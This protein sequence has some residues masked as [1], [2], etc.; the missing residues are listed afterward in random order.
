MS[1]TLIAQQLVVSLGLGMLIGFQRERSDRS[2][3][4]IRTFPLVTL[5]GTIS[6]QLA[7][8]YGGLIVAAG[9]LAL[10]ALTFLPNLPRFRTQEGTGVTSEIALL[11]LYLL[12]AF[13]VIEPLY[14]V[15]VT[16]GA[17]ALLL[18]AKQ[19]LHRFAN[20]VGDDEMRAIMRF[21][22][23]SM[24]ILPI[25]PNEAFGPYAAF[26]LF[27]TW[28]MVVL[29]VGIS[30][31]GYVAYKIFGGRD[32]VLLAGL[33]GGVISSTATTVS[34]ARRTK[35]APSTASL[36]AVMIMIASTVAIVRALIEIALA[37]PHHIGAFLLPLGILLDAMIIFAG[38]AYLRI[39]KEN[40][41][42]LEQGNPAELKTALIFAIAYTVIK[43]AVA[44]G[45]HHFDSSGLYLIGVISGLADMDAITL[46]TA[47]LVESGG[48]PAET[49]WRIILL[50]AMSNLGF[51]TFAVAAVGGAP[52][53]KKVA[54]LF[55][56]SILTGGLIL[57]LWR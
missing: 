21:V 19:S 22:L 24:V 47:R 30:L 28:L 13:L 9:L 10:T 26:N 32:G 25:L 52:L 6:G 23:I 12:G 55:G 35:S 8:A 14:L 56:A 3:G 53:F 50:A 33:L 16:G 42:A 37:A 1:D 45:R 46:S 57:W 49:G 29:I 20:A 51:K 7:Q 39:R 18:Q 38:C 11:L 31:C 5:L 15:V 44:A 40:C 17:V 41:V 34:A 36:T 4:G 54:L 43:F 48:I 2:I 27:E